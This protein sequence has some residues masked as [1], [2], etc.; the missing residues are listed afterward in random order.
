MKRKELLR[1]SL[2]RKTGNTLEAVKNYTAGKDD[3]P[4]DPKGSPDKKK[5]KRSF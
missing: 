2:M 5:E 1:I 4:K 3:D